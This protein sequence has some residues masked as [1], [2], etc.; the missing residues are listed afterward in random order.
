MVL[1]EDKFNLQLDEHISYKYFFLS[2]IDKCE[3]N[4]KIML[5]NAIISLINYRIS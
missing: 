5:L 1:A 2:L 3:Y 4:T